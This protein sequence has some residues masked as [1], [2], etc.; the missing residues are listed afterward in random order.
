MKRYE[1]KFTFDRLLVYFF[2]VERIDRN[3][4]IKLWLSTWNWL[5]LYVNTNTLICVHSVWC[6]FW[7][8]ASGLRV[9]CSIDKLDVGGKKHGDNDTDI[10]GTRLENSHSFCESIALWFVQ[11]L[12]SCGWSYSCFKKE[13]HFYNNELRFCSM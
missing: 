5:F 9:Q 10:H 6:S 13:I 1:A 4:E 2:I 11:I 7:N 3:N 12:L 8:A